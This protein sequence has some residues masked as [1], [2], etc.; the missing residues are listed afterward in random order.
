M[1]KK[2]SLAGFAENVGSWGL[3]FRNPFAPQNSQLE[4]MF[5]N[6]RWCLITNFRSILSTLN[7][8]AY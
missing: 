8:S 5:I 1:K 6:T 2:N 3:P 7:I 4:T